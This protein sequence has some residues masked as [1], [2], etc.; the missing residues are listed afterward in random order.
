MCGAAI[1][2][3]HHRLCRRRNNRC[4]GIDAGQSE[5]GLLALE[6]DGY[7]RMI[8][9]VT[10]A[11]EV[12]QLTL[13]KKDLPEVGPIDTRPRAPLPL[14]DLGPPGRLIPLGDASLLASPD[15]GKTWYHTAL[16]GYVA[17]ENPRF[18]TAPAP[19]GQPKPKGYPN[20]AY[21]CGNNALFV[22]VARECWRSMD[23]G[24]SWDLGSVLFTILKFFLVVGYAPTYGAWIGLILAFTIAY[25]GYMK[26][27]ELKITRPPVGASGF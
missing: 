15:D 24:R 3:N 27:Q 8:E 23:G 11:F 19:K 18:M 2:L 13:C 20:V 16:P 22:Y 4:L 1:K 17:S 10:A 21:W 12:N 9:A 7:L 6:S 25:G 26:M 14:T 5:A